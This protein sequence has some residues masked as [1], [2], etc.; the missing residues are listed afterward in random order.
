VPEPLARY[1][2]GE[3]SNVRVVGLP[4]DPPT[5]DLKQFWHRRY[6]GDARNRWLRTR[7]YELFRARREAGS[8]QPRKRRA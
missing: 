4:F 2:A 8:R 7:I 1:F 5:I 6:H 3:W